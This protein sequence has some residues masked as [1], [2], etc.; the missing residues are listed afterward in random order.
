MTFPDCSKPNQAG[1]DHKEHAVIAFVAGY[2]TSV[3][4]EPSRHQ[5]LVW[6]CC[7]ARECRRPGNS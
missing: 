7:L 5:E 3:M 2:L 4:I 1:D 6:N